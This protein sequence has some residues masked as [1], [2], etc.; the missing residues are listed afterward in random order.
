MSLEQLR[1]LDEYRF[2]IRALDGDVKDPV[3][4]SSYPFF[5][6][7]VETTFELSML[8][9]VDF[10]FAY[11]IGQQ[12]RFE[13]YA[14]RYNRDDSQRETL[15]HLYEILK[16]NNPDIGSRVGVFKI[17]EWNHV[18]SKSEMTS[19]S[20]KKIAVTSDFNVSWWVH[21]LNGTGKWMFANP[22]LCLETELLVGKICQQI[23]EESS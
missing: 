1:E 13:L 22:Q 11:K 18:F 5:V 4:L 14:I 23:V 3:K 20:R 17:C 7:P 2:F 12:V 16:R 8:R 6:K 19:L 21:K 15:S 10:N 9:D